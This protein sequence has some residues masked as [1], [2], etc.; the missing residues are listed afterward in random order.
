MSDIQFTKWNSSIV[1][2]D[3]GKLDWNN[4]LHESDIELSEGTVS[5]GYCQILDIACILLQ[6]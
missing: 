2:Y 4:E 5:G 6:K 1:E 3:T